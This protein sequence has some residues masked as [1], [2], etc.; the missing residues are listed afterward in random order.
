MFWFSIF[1]VLLADREKGVLL[2]DREKKSD[3]LIFT[4]SVKYAYLFFLLIKYLQGIAERIVYPS[5][6]P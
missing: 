6:M 1:S 4:G 5:T 3:K 2:A